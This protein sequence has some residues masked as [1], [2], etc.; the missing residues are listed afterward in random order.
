MSDDPPFLEIGTLVS[1]K[2]KGAYCESTVLAINRSL[3]VKVTLKESPF[4][5]L[6]VTDK[7]LSNVKEF[8]IGAKADV[9][10]QKRYYR[11]VITHIKDQSKYHVEFN[12]GDERWL[13]R[14]QLVT[15]GGRHFDAEGNLDAMPLTNP[16]TFLAPVRRRRDPEAASTSR[17][18]DEENPEDEEEE[19]EKPPTPRPKERRRAAR[20]AM[21]AIGDMRGVIND[22]QSEDSA[23]EQRPGNRS[24]RKRPADTEQQEVKEEKKEVKEEDEDS[25]VNGSG[26]RGTRLVDTLKL[27]KKEKK[28]LAR[29]AE[30]EQKLKQKEDEKEEKAKKMEEEKERRKEDKARAAER[31][32][33][34]KIYKKTAEMTSNR[35]ERAIRQILAHKS[36]RYSLFQRKERKVMRRVIKKQPPPPKPPKKTRPAPNPQYSE[37]DSDDGMSEDNEKDKDKKFKK[38]HEIRRKRT[39]DDRRKKSEIVLKVLDVDTKESE[40]KAG[41]LTPSPKFPYKSPTGSPKKVEEKP[42]TPPEYE[43]VLVSMKPKP[44]VRRQKYRIRNALLFKQWRDCSDHLGS[45]RRCRYHRQW[46]RRNQEEMKNMKRN[47]KL[48]RNERRKKLLRLWFK[49]IE[50]EKYAHMVVIHENFTEARKLLKGFEKEVGE[51]MTY[52]ERCELDYEDVESTAIFNHF[53]EQEWYTAVLFPQTFPDEN[54]DVQR[55]VRHMGNGKLIR[56]WEDDIVPFYWIPDFTYD[57]QQA[58]I[59]SRPKKGK[60]RRFWLGWRFTMDYMMERLHLKS[61]SA[62]LKCRPRDIFTIQERPDRSAEAAFT[63]APSPMKRDDSV[64]DEDEV[65]EENP[66]DDD[67]DEEEERSSRSDSSD[68]DSDASIK[69][70]DQEKKDTF[71]V[72]LL[73]FY[74]SRD[75]EVDT[76]RTI[77]GVDLDLYY[78]YELAMRIGP[79]KKVYAANPW[80]AWGKKLVPNAVNPEE[81][82]KKAFDECLDTFMGVHAKLSWPIESLQPRSERRQVL[83]GQ[84]SESRKKR[85]LA[86]GQVAQTPKSGKRK[87]KGQSPTDSTIGGRKSRTNTLSPAPSSYDPDQPGPSNAIY[88]DE[89]EARDDG[90]APSRKRKKS[91]TPARRSMSHKDESDTTPTVPKKGRPRKEPAKVQVKAAPPEKV[92]DE[93]EYVRANVLSNIQQSDPIKALF[94]GQWYSAMAVEVPT[95]FSTDLLKIMLKLQKDGSQYVPDSIGTEI[96]QLWE[97]MRLK[98]HYTGWNSRYDEFKDLEEVMVTAEDQAVAR[99]RFRDLPNGMKLKA[100][101]MAI[102]EKYFCR[103]EKKKKINHL[104]LAE[105]ALGTME[106]DSEASDESRSGSPKSKSPVSTREESDE[107][108]VDVEADD[109]EEERRKKKRSYS[110]A[111]PE[112]GERSLTP[113][114]KSSVVAPISERSAEKNGAKEPTKAM[115]GSPELGDLSPGS[116][117]NESPEAAKAPSPMDDGSP[118]LGDVSPTPPPRDETPEEPE[119]PTRRETRADSDDGPKTLRELESESDEPEYPQ[120]SKSPELLFDDAGGSP[121]PPVLQPPME[122]VNSAGSSNYPTLSRQGSSTNSMLSATTPLAHSGPL[123]LEEVPLTAPSTSTTHHLEETNKRRRRV[124]SGAEEGS[125]QKRVR[126][127]SERSG[128]SQPPPLLTSQFSSGAL[129]LEMTTESSGP[130]D[131]TMVTVSKVGRR[132]TGTQVFQQQP[133]PTLLSSG[134]LTLHSPIAPSPAPLPKVRPPGAP[135]LGRPKKNSAPAPIQPRKEPEEEPA[136]IAEPEPREVEGTSEGSSTPPEDKEDGLSPRGVGVAGRGGKRKRGGGRVGG[137]STKT[138]PKASGSA[139]RSN[140]DESSED[141]EQGTP[142]DIPTPYLPLPNTPST[143]AT[144]NFASQKARMTKQM[145][146]VGITHDFK[147][148]EHIIDHVKVLRDAPPEDINMNLEE[149]S[150]EARDLFFSLKSDLLALDKAFRK[151]E[152]ARKKMAEAAEAA[153]MQ[154]DS[155]SPPSDQPSTSSNPSNSSPPL[156]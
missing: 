67:D 106:V 18:D 134:P 74:D 114:T 48:L 89:E 1:S 109:E 145:E 51:K 23:D 94:K 140:A 53:K 155:N 27:T 42:P 75:E 45:S 81:E 36:L 113:P 131:P 79:P 44:I 80:T 132:K 117:L 152:L 32:R 72:R 55:V 77:Q 135:P 14:T 118:E 9:S 34:E 111:S 70:A 102:V 49:G 95:D 65:K 62:M 11:C 5:S 129:T 112:L 100:R 128:F 136:P 28:R 41:S 137:S 60:R 122:Q 119:E 83:P 84:Y 10:H 103:E 59:A 30:K 86:L 39:G 96:E 22:T 3:R 17:Q 68:Y 46:R 64:V 90:V 154:N 13:R 78:M 138:T 133:S 29:I 146:E 61:L 148:I 150:N 110:E 56:V 99:K 54:G 88:S 21:S 149:L 38:K 35:N 104:K 4:G 91:R 43:D 73:Q 93:P 85:A 107:E 127:I 40:T 52:D 71:L 108:N 37:H 33:I 141:K 12:D 101:T 19:E 121:Q 76:N 120:M 130:I 105:D 66:E 69:N 144:D 47:V 57:E 2:F 142:M 26:A 124:S 82:L 24:K 143:R 115:S 151:S 92:N 16:E 7:E 156:A 97:L 63:T 15:Q 116:S 126:R 50:K 25:Q 31:K 125:P 147:R 20:E 153:E 87:R 8:K 123:T 6:S 58:V 139:R 98:A